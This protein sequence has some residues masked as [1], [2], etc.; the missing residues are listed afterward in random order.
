MLLTVHGHLEVQGTWFHDGITNHLN[1]RVVAS[2]HMQFEPSCKYP[3][4]RS[5]DVQRTPALASAAS[6]D[7]L[8]CPRMLRSEAQPKHH[9]LGEPPLVAF[10]SCQEVAMEAADIEIDV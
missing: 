10:A 1:K 3:G 9:G 2:L 7:M 5:M 8:C 6:S 4:P